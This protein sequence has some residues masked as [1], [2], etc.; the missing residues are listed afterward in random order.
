VA[1]SSSAN[2]SGVNQPATF[3]A[4]VTPSGAGQPA[5]TVT[6]LD[7]ATVLGAATM[8]NGTA[9]LTTILAT[10]SHAITATYSGD[11]TFAASSSAALTQ[12]V[13]ASNTSTTTTVTSSRN[14]S[15]TG[16]SVTL[17]GRVTSPAGTP[18]GT[19]EF[20]D[21][22][23][24]IGTGTLSGSGQATLTTTTLAVGSHAIT[25][26][27]LGSATMPP[28]LSATLVQVVNTS[29]TT[30][31][32]TTTTLTAS[33]STGSYG[34]QTTFSVSVAPPALQSAPTG[35]VVF[36]IDGV[37]STVVALTASNG[38]GVATLSTSTLPRGKHLVTV[39]YLGSGTYAG[40]TATLT[41]TVN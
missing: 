36:T 20:L 29:S 3:T 11:A 23:V 31:K 7:G 34:T 8:Q 39:T 25:V 17:T 30:A 13:N 6:F 2:P 38:K 22:N 41:Y 28:S 19:I 27:Y 5:G 4:S 12:T 9:S 24:V 37:S 1:V 32:S 16:Q 33:P 18:A 26:R 15:K 21:G 10:G 14:P 35:N 40:S